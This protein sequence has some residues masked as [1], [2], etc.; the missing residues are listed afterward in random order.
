LSDRLGAGRQAEAEVRDWNDDD[1]QLEQWHESHLGNFSYL[2]IFVVVTLVSVLAFV[3]VWLLV[4]AQRAVAYVG[5]L[6]S[7]H[8]RLPG[9]FRG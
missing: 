9:R 6:F 2:A 7:R 1:R 4:Q 3:P 5:A 8:V